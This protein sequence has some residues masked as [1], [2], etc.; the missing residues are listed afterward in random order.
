MNS[1]NVHP[2]SKNC[3]N[4]W[5]GP[6]WSIRPRECLNSNP[7]HQQLNNKVVKEVLNLPIEFKRRHF[8]PMLLIK[9]R[10]SSPLSLQFL[11]TYAITQR[12]KNKMLQSFGVAAISKIH[13][14]SFSSGFLSF[15]SPSI[16]IVTNKH[17]LVLTKQSCTA[18][19][20]MCQSRFYED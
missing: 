20:D 8:F 14:C 1:F 17:E 18:F 12:A 10:S 15:F 7:T 13:F 16:F 9:Q 3:L 6:A 5:L 11:Y 2:R 19:F 4:L